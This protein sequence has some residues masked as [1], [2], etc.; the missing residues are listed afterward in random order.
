MI[1]RRILLKSLIYGSIQISTLN[2]PHLETCA[3][4]EPCSS[5]LTDDKEYIYCE[6]AQ[7]TQFGGWLLDTQFVEQMGSAYLL[8]SGMGSPVADAEV[9]IPVISPGNYRVWIR[10]KDWYPPYSPGRFAITVNGRR[11]PMKFGKSD[12]TS[13]KWVTDDQTYMLRSSASITLKDLTGYYGRCA[14]II[15]TNDPSFHPPSNV[16]I[17]R[18]SLKE[19]AGNL[20]VPEANQHSEIVVVG[21]GIAGCCA[22]LAVARLGRKVYLVTDRPVLGGNCSEEIFVVPYGATSISPYNYYWRETGII[23]EIEEDVVWQYGASE[24]TGWSRVLLSLILEEANITLLTGYRLIDVAKVPDQAAI[25]SVTCINVDTRTKIVLN[26]RYFVDATGDGTLGALSDVT[27]RYGRESS[28]EFGESLAPRS[29]DRAV[30]GATLQF[31]VRNLGSRVNYDCPDWVPQFTSEDFSKGG[32]DP[33]RTH[34]GYWWIE[35]G[36]LHK[37]KFLEDAELIRDTLLLIL[38][39]VWNYKKNRSPERGDMRNYGLGYVATVLGKRE[40]RRIEGDYILTQNDVQN[41]ASFPD[42]VAYGGWRID[43]HDPAGFYSTS[44]QVVNPVFVLP[45]QIPL[46]ML[47]SK[48][49]SNLFMAGRCHSASHVGLGS[50]RVMKTLG[51]CGQAVGTAAHLCLERQVE[52]RTLSTEHIEEL[53][54]LLLKGDVYLPRIKNRDSRDI[55]RSATVRA[56]SMA[57]GDFTLF[58]ATSTCSLCSMSLQRAVVFPTP[59]NGVLHDIQLLLSSTTAQTNVSTALYALNSS[60]PPSPDSRPLI[61]AKLKAKSIARW[62]KFDINKR[63]RSPYCCLTIEPNAYANCY[64]MPR[65]LAQFDSYYWDK[66]DWHPKFAYEQYAIVV[67][68]GN[69]RAWPANVLNG[70]NRFNENVWMSDPK[71][72]LPS[73]IEL[74]FGSEKDF[75]T[76]LLY[77]DTDL[78]GGTCSRYSWVPEDYSIMHYSNSKWTTCVNETKNY[79]RFRRH[80]FE[81]TSASKL[82][83]TVQKARNGYTFARIYEIRVYLDR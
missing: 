78:S 19:R 49:L 29:R 1:S 5:P 38:Y 58:P 18:K 10:C 48:D 64:L 47:Y 51:L 31:K 13:W 6:A 68:G 67:D 45:Y 3:D 27:L 44:P 72:G 14:G 65:T 4:Y 76:V 21:G 75:N 81:D 83:V 57:E 80:S 56:S 61:R 33:D 70:V 34:D 26:A 20:S 37:T 54:Q 59:E 2:I 46:R 12:D 74:D 71:R 28:S 25:K 42:T 79:H 23:G 55:A 39:G 41:Q 15:L 63:I 50:A 60:T 77:F 9:T 11:S 53:Q 7:F 69:L 52:P 22:A 66:E 35:Y 30:S 17:L 16:E 36:G 32:R 40:S 62:V 8:A 73:W 24:R 43:L 82:R